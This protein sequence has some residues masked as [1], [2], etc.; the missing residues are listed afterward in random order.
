MG[1]RSTILAVSV[2]AALGNAAAFADVLWTAEAGLGNS[3]NVTRVDTGEV[4]ES[5]GTVGLTLDWQTEGPRLTANANVDAD[6]RHYFDGTYD[7][8]VVGTGD[9]ALLFGIIPE[10]FTWLVQD[11]FGQ[12]LTDPFAP[13][14]PE[15]RENVNYFTTGP[16]FAMRL[17]GSLALNLFATYSDSEY[18]RSP[19][20]ST[21]ISG[22]ATLGRGGPTNRGLSLSA[23]QEKV[24]FDDQPGADFDRQSLFLGYGIEGARTV[25]TA[26]AGYTWLHPETGDDSG[27]PR[28]EIDVT[29]EMSSAATLVFRIGTQL[30]DSSDM[31]RSAA[32]I[33][34]APPGSDST[35]VISTADPF[36]NRYASLDWNYSR[37]RT[38]FS[39]TAGYADD[40]YETLTELD[41]TTMSYGASAERQL[42][43]RWTA[44]LY[45]S[46]EQ[47][48]FDNADLSTDT[49]EYGATLD[50]QLGRAISLRLSLE[51]YDRDTSDGLGEFLENRVFLSVIYRGAPARGG[52]RGG[53]PRR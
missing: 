41:R 35:G 23:V 24:E 51:R 10:R 20:D 42:S 40:T 33:G 39:L 36:E 13:V 5:I 19:L 12:A 48:D 45:A 25:L 32:E 37:N 11:S 3:D 4:E 22:G 49:L 18:E 26:E 21:R 1:R 38:S 16:R 43:A 7:D 52:P 9:A 30:T 29:R 50:W 46:M 34:G 31:L 2:L 47:E 8:E 15:T 28:F 53:S 17:G 14:T 44:S 27:A 6:Y